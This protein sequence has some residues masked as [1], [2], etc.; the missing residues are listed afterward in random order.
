MVELEIWPNV[1]KESIFY[2]AESAIDEANEVFDVIYNLGTRNG[3]TLSDLSPM[4]K[5]LVLK[6]TNSLWKFKPLL[7]SPCIQLSR[8]RW[9]T[10]FFTRIPDKFWKNFT[11]STRENSRLQ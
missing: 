7:E 1:E 2:S 11:H 9:H 8:V 3:S 5:P 10:S 6:S 4:E